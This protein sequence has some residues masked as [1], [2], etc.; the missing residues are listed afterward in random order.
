AS[1]QSLIQELRRT[2]GMAII[3]RNPGN[4]DK[5]S[6][7]NAITD[8]IAGGRVFL[9]RNAHWLDDFI[10]EAT[11]FPSVE[12]D[13]QVD[14]FEILIDALSRVH[15]TPASFDTPIF[16]KHSLANQYQQQQKKTAPDVDDGWG[17]SFNANSLAKELSG[18]KWKGWGL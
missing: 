9:P 3:P 16:V 13:D 6:R 18:K 5:V 10:A 17:Q 8:L 4:K 11:A 7:V 1:G 15:V 14:A 12:H 2:S